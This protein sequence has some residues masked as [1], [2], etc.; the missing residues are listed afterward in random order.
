MD[1]L[2]LL[3]RSNA[4]EFPSILNNATAKESNSQKRDLTYLCELEKTN[5]WITAIFYTITFY[6]LILYKDTCIR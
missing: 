5:E 1:V 2:R 6:I 4:I 3:S